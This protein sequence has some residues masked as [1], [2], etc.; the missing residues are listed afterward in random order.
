MAAD[1]AP[2]APAARLDRATLTVSV[3]PTCGEAVI[4]KGQPAWSEH[5]TGQRGE[6]VDPEESMR[7]SLART[8]RKVRRWCTHHRAT[9]L[10]TLTFAEEPDLDTAWLKIEAFRR[11][12]D[13]AGIPQPLIVPERGEKNG[14]LHFHLAL[15]Q[16]VPKE[17]LS[18][19]WGHGFVDVRRIKPKK[20]PGQ[21]RIGGR[22]Q[23]RIVAGYVAGYVAKQLRIDA[24]GDPEGRAMAGGV[25]FNRRRYS[26]PK[27]SSPEPVRFS[28]WSVFDA[29]AEIGNQCGHALTPVWESS[30]VE[31]WRG[32][33]TALLMG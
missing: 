23:A 15:P 31:D 22:E 12:L 30:S 16:Y 8:R 1:V 19:L 28:C 9:R 4:V 7:S 27:N 10:G 2:Y 14:R 32:P 18:Q 26:V 11:R 3:Y 21:S 29:W 33:P 20:Q 25:G 6:A 17:L 13:E 24:A 5:G